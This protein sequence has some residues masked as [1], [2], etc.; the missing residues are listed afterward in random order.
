MTHSATICLAEM[1]RSTQS[2]PPGS[3]L[4]L[5]AESEQE[6]SLSSSATQTLL[7]FDVKC[8]VS[9]M[10][11]VE[12]SSTEFLLLQGFTEISYSHVFL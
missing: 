3:T 6:V 12:I 7:F 9:F 2:L 5:L 11:A 1:K 4:Q 10:V 8:F